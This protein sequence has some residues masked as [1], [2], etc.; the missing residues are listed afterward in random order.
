MNHAAGHEF[1][2][3]Q[4]PHGPF[5]CQLATK[6]LA[7]GAGVRRIAFNPGDESEWGGSKW[8]E[9]GPLGRYLGPISAYP[10]WLAHQLTLYRITDI[11][12]YGDTRPEHAHAIKVARQRGVLCHCLEEGY[13]R[14]HCVTYER[15][16]NIG[17]SPLRD[18]SL[19]RMAQA[20]G[21]AAPPAGE[22]DDGWG[23]HRPHLWHSALYH[24]RL[25]LPSRRY[26]RHRSC[27]D[28]TLWRE[29]G[30]YLR[31]FAGLPLRRF[32][33]G[34]Q[35][36]QLLSSGKSYHLVLL[37]LS[38]DCS[39]QIHSDYSN[40]AEFVRDCIGAF[41]RGAP[42]E[43]CLVFK[44]HP[45]EDGRECLGQ[46]IAD[47]AERLGVDERVIF[48]DGGPTLTSLLDGALSAVT[49]NSTAAQLA[50]WRGLPVATLG[51]A[52]YAKPGLVSDQA[53]D[54]FFAAPRRPDQQAYWQFR[55]FL[56]ESSQ[57]KGSFYSRHGIVAL[58]DTLPAA[59]MAP[60]DAY[61]RALV[62]APGEKRPA[63]VA[64]LATTSIP[65]PVELREIPQPHRVAV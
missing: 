55:R 40:S 38:F 6:L 44:S 3:L 62:P 20:L 28:L 63:P 57:L 5:F 60:V 59:I 19:A 13:L 54:A 48:L 49:V 65:A 30:H 32:A 37:Q 15:W 41:V 9:I 64:Q 47:T 17:N 4:G 25:L 34:I 16:G 21:P 1:L 29:M 36:R 14:P 18:I 10:E 51:R 7:A 58:L 22:P 24:A 8:A 46:V 27:R 11:I 39:M 42:V 35:A 56:S 23:A 53:L 12:L 26:G 61:E 33:Q 52:V 45:F 2:F 31:R 50:L 43:D